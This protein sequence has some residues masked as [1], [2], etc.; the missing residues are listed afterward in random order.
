MK[1]AQHMKSLLVERVSGGVEAQIQAVIATKQHW[2][3]LSVIAAKLQ[4]LE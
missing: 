3:T 4:T 1:E 2:C